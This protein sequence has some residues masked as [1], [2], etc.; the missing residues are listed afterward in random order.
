TFSPALGRRYN[1]WR[2]LTR[3]T[4]SRCQI[5]LSTAVCGRGC[6]NWPRLAQRLPHCLSHQRGACV[7]ANK[8]LHRTEQT[9]T[10]FAF[11]KR[12]PVCS[13]AELCRSADQD[14]GSPMTFRSKIDAWIALLSIGAVVACLGGLIHVAL[15]K[16]SLLALAMSPLLLVGVVLPVW[17][18]SSTYYVLNET[19][20]LVRSGP[21]QWRVPLAD[22]RA[23]T[24]T[25]N[26]LS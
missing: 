6:P 12:A 4:R 10:R 13:A 21:L 19:E 20:L 1:E 18:L 11:A 25:R 15:T 24:P 16:S 26:P 3:S 22:I 23:I 8:S 2:T 14:R 7:R 17:L 9:V 5:S